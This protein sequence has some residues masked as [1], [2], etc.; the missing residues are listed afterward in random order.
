MSQGPGSVAA[1]VGRYLDHLT[2]ER[3]LAAHT[4]AAY[5][6][7]LARYR[8]ALAARGRASLAEVSAADVTAFLAGLREGDEDHP[9]LAASSAARAVVAVRGLHAFAAAEG[10]APADPAHEVRPPAP[11]RRLPRGIGVA[12]TERL[13]AAAG[14]DGDPAGPRA[15]RDRALLE[16]LY[17]TG[18]RIS[19]A[20]T[21]DLDDLRLP[22]PGEGGGATATV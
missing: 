21:L 12:E 2:V 18:A 16:F 11:P 14:A 20:V 9:P 6:R 8:T 1:A 22:P 19:E 17:G 3:G 7:D 13:I 15:L 10:L 4:L 5:R